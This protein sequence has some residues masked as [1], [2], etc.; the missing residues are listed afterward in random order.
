M[1]AASAANQAEHL[2]ILRRLLGAKPVATVP[3]A[4]ETGTAP[5][6]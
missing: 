3:D 2:A 5:P 6:P 1:L 4:F